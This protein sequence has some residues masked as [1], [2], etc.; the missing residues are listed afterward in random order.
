[1]LSFKISLLNPLLRCSYH[2][3]CST[4]A[5]PRVPPQSLLLCPLLVLIP[6]LPFPSRSTPLDSL[7]VSQQHYSVLLVPTTG[8]PTA[9]S[10]IYCVRPDYKAV[11]VVLRVLK[12][13]VHDS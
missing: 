7:E 6:Q 2:K 4:I 9:F 13:F 5:R 11:P 10:K 12:Y 1:M 3:Q 8:L